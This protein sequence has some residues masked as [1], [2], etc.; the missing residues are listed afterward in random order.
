MEDISNIRYINY[1][2]WNELSKNTHSPLVAAATIRDGVEI[3][4]ISNSISIEGV[5]YLENGGD[6][7]P[8]ILLTSDNQN[9]IILEGHSRMTVYGLAPNFFEGSKCYIGIC[10]EEELHRWNG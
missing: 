5:K 9:Y 2:Y 4:G 10:N 7:L 3:Y 6:F 1:S 8:V